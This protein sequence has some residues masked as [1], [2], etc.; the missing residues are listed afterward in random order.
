MIKNGIHL[1]YFQKIQLPHHTGGV[2]FFLDHVYVFFSWSGNKE[3]F[4]PC[5]KEPFII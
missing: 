1:E 4:L 2:E 5:Y 3:I